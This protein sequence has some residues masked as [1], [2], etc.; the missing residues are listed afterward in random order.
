MQNTKQAVVW[1]DLL[2]PNVSGKLPALVLSHGCSGISP[3]AYDVWAEEMNAAGVAIF[4][5]DSIQSRGVG[6]T[7]IDQSKVTFP[8]QISN[9]LN[10]L[11]L[12]AAHPQ[13]DG[14]RI[15]NIAKSRGGGVAFDKA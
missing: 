10:A 6:Q 11:K 8:A 14:T 2:L 4:I 9:A 3:T 13:I 1:S 5:I 7:E 15:F 12:L